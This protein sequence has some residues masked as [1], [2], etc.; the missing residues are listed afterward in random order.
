MDLDIIL[1][2]GGIAA[3]LIII[4]GIFAAF[5]LVAGHIATRLGFTGIMWW[6]VSFVSFSVLMGLAGG[7]ST[8]VK[9]N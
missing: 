8:T 5:I 2:L 9:K 6:A 4:I 7:I 1:G 3:Y